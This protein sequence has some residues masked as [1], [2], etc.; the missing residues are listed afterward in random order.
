[1][2]FYACYYNFTTQCLCDY[3][4]VDNDKGCVASWDSD[5]TELPKLATSDFVSRGRLFVI[6]GTP[7]SLGS[8]LCVRLEPLTTCVLCSLIFLNNVAN[9]YKIQQDMPGIPIILFE[10]LLS[11]FFLYTL[12]FVWLMFRQLF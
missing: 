11:E 9:K 4:C 5:K 10:E 3:M 1:M 7:N 2:P 12:H 8:Y 6:S